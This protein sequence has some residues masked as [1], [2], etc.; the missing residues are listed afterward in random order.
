VGVCGVLCSAH[1]GGVF[2]VLC[3]CAGANTMAET[4]SKMT[5]MHG[6]AEGGRV[7]VRGAYSATHGRPGLS[8]AG[9][10]SHVVV[11]SSRQH[12]TFFFII[13][14]IPPQG[15]HRTLA[16]LAGPRASCPADN[17]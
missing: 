6:A 1:G 15:L 14:T 3:A 12:H 8:E 17:R 7:E 10:I 11:V 9:I 2:H 5:P 16:D 13:P 4:S